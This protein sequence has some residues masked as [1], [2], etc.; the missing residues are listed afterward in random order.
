MN[1]HVPPSAARRFSR[2]TVWLLAAIVPTLG[3]PPSGQY[4]AD[5]VAD[6]VAQ[7]DDLAPLKDELTRVLKQNAE[8]RRLFV[9]L[10]GAWQVLHGVLAYGSQFQL[11]SD[12][13]TQN[14]LSFLVSG[15]AV[16]GFQPE[17]GDALGEPPRNGVR[18]GLDPSTKVGQGHRDQWL[19]VIAQAGLTL[20]DE[21]VGGDRV[22]RMEDWVRQMKYDIPL[23]FEREYSWTLIALTTYHDTDHRWTAR[24]GNDYSVESLL[25]S[26]INQDVETSACGGTHRLI[27]IAMALNRRKAEGKPVIGVWSDAQ[28]LVSTAIELAQQNQNGDG[29]FSGSYFHRA[30]P[31]MDLAEGLGTTGHVLEFLA[32]AAPDKVLSQPWVERSARHLMRTLDSCRDI[33]L[34]CGVLYHA[35][36]GLQELRSR[37]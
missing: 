19:A 29:S 30:G 36:H 34:E 31:T 13:G 20:Q 21:L 12:Q 11:Q 5:K 14:A 23:N 8:G 16:S 22:F 2:S 15:G 4:G 33:D 10:H 18:M 1:A 6:L 26:E 32:L 17:L 35:L 25:Q 28:Q 37:I 24:D 7:E 9:P 3:C 27:G